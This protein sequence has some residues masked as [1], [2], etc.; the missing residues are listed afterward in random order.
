MDKT[1]TLPAVTAL[2]F[3]ATMTAVGCAAPTDGTNEATEAAIHSAAAPSHSVEENLARLRALEI[4]EVGHFLN[5]IPE[6]ANCYGGPTMVGIPCPDHEQEF[7][8]AKAAS[9]KRLAEFTD[10]AERLAA[11]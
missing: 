7:A 1:N 11:L 6:A 8:D 5:H 2:T 9:E 4:F 10:R 3:I